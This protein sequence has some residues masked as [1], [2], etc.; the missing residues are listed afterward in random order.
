M[1]LFV[2]LNYHRLKWIIIGQK[3]I[4][5]WSESMFLSVRVN[6]HWWKLII[7]GQYVWFQN[8][9]IG[10]SEC[11]IHSGQSDNISRGSYMSCRLL[12]WIWIDHP[13]RL[14]SIFFSWI[15]HYSAMAVK[16]NEASVGT[17][18]YS[19][20]V[21]TTIVSARMFLSVRV[22]PHREVVQG[23]WTF[24]SFSIVLN[25]HRL[26]WIIIGQKWITIESESMFLSVR[27]NYHGWKWIIIGQYVC[28]C[29]VR[30]N[31]HWS[32]S[33]NYHRCECKFSFGWKCIIIGQYACFSQLEWIIIGQ[34]EL[35]TVRTHVFFN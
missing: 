12:T 24:S 17:A 3:W 11:I 13:F 33:M 30:V 5:Y 28:F 16:V 29:H 18:S 31:Y 34:S 26:K 14:T 32:E 20:V 1:F 25:Y 9:I 4:T 23:E 10:G 21:W 19:G 35:S 27:V 22:N 2:R 15:W 7:I 8:S 6:Y